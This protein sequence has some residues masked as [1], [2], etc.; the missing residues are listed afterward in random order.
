MVPATCYPN[1][2]NNIVKWLG[3]ARSYVSATFTSGASPFSRAR[4]LNSDCFV[5]RDL[6]RRSCGGNNRR[7]VGEERTDLG[8]GCLSAMK[9]DSYFRS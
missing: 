4:N 3:N 7:P 6:Y 1:S 8:F 2:P 9:A 5:L